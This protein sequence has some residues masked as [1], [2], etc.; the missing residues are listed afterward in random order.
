[1]ALPFPHHMIAA[2]DDY[3]E[4]VVIIDRRTKRIVWQY[5][6][7]GAAGSRPGYLNKPNGLDLIR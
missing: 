7:Q 5:G 6:H 4:R 3:G 1:L 2:T